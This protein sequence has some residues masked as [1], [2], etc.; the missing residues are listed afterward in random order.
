MSHPTHPD[1]RPRPRPR[2]HRDGTAPVWV[3]AWGDY[4][5][6]TATLP[7]RELYT[8]SVV[9]ASLP[10]STQAATPHRSR[11]SASSTKLLQLRSQERHLCLYPVALPS[12]T[13]WSPNSPRRGTTGEACKVQ[14]L[15]TIPHTSYH[16]SLTHSHHLTGSLAH[17]NSLPPTQHDNAFRRRRPPN[18]KPSHTRPQSR[19]DSEP[20]S[21]SSSSSSTS[22]SISIPLPS[23]LLLRSILQADVT[24]TQ[25]NTLHQPLRALPPPPPPPPS[26]PQ[27]TTHPPSQPRPRPSVKV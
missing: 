24:S 2:R 16:P 8:K 21:F 14:H 6:S 5:T 12:V 25:Y 27:P 17:S 13:K 20:R 11:R 19:V 10:V 23:H 3:S 18:L 9:S 1:L 7:G 4:R 15:V 26:P 22:I